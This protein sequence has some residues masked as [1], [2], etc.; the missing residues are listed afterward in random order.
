MTHLGGA[1]ALTVVHLRLSLVPVLIGL[2]IAVP[3]GLLVHRAPTLRRKMYEAFWRVHPKM[4][5]WGERLVETLKQNER[6]PLPVEGPLLLGQFHNRYVRDGFFD[7]DGVLWAPDGTVVAQSRQL[8][9]LL[10][11]EA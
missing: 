1:W 4:L 10:G 7:E 5:R 6:S 3:W 2:A 11:A 9:L 8:G